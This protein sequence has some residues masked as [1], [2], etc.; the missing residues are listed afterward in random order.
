MKNIILVFLGG[1]L[2]SVCRY[3]I[4]RLLNNP[5]N[6]IAFGTW[7]VNVVGC[8]ILGFILGTGIK[9]EYFSNNT[10][11][12]IATGFCGGFTTFS[13]FAFENQFLLKTGDYSNFA[14]YTLGSLILGFG[15]VFVGLFLSKSF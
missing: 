6:P 8:L 13:T 12:F 15:A 14:I 5:E 11:L 1:G 7:T 3:L 4:S 9:N 10:L 2:G